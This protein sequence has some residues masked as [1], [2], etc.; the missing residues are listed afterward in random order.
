MM[1]R[2]ER[3]ISSSLKEDL[4]SGCL[5]G[6]IKNW[7]FTSVL[8][9]NLKTIFFFFFQNLK[10]IMVAT[11]PTRPRPP[12]DGRATPSSQNAANGATESVGQTQLRLAMLTVL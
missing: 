6:T 8:F 3:A 7:G 2:M 5:E 1:L 11:L 4:I 9:Q 10:T 12:T